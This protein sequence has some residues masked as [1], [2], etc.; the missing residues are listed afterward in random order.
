MYG[1]MYG[2]SYLGLCSERS[3]IRLQEDEVSTMSENDALGTENKAESLSIS[4]REIELTP[5]QFS[6]FVDLCSEGRQASEKIREAA[7][8]LDIEGF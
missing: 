8:R 4:G 2:L 6:R 7:K 1:L 3:N 5:E